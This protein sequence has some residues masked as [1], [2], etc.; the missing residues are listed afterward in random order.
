M[1]DYNEIRE[2]FYHKYTKEEVQ[3]QLKAFIQQDLDL[4]TFDN[5]GKRYDKIINAFFEK[6]I[7]SARNQ[8]CKISPN[9][10]LYDDELLDRIYEYVDTKPKFYTDDDVANLKTFFRNAGK[11]ACKV[12]NFSPNVARKIYERYMP[13]ENANILDYSCGFGSRM[14]G[15]LSSKYNYRYF[16]IDPNTDLCKHLN[17]MG[18]F[19]QETKPCIYKIFCQGSEET[20]D[21]LENKID[22]AFSS[23]PYFNLEIYNN[24]PTQSTAKFSDYERWLK[25]YVEPTIQNIYRYLKD[26]GLFILNI[27]NM[28]RGGKEPLL[29]DWIKI[30][31]QNGFKLR[32]IEN[33][34]HQTSKKALAKYKAEK[35]ENYKYTGDSEPLVIFVKNKE[36][37]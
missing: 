2:N 31:E 29:D 14:L 23:P 3:R 15:C 28:T 1:R 26:D 25:Y 30:A 13:K 12:A 35:G 9:E 22:L 6:N 27:K 8:R 36:I 19:I 18:K 21:I 16:G 11:W 10:A 33:M 37:K 32:E 34:K 7:Y 20:V 5:K 24:E 17:A 4:S